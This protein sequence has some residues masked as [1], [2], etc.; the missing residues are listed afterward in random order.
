V[1]GA[2]WFDHA[3]RLHAQHPDGPLPH[4]GRPFP[5]SLVSPQ[6]ALDSESGSLVAVPGGDLSAADIFAGL[7]KQAGSHRWR[8]REAGVRLV[9]HGATPA[10]VLGGIALLGYA[11]HAEDAALLKVIGLLDGFGVAA[12]EALAA[13]PDATTNLLQLAYRSPDA[14]A[15]VRRNAVTDD[16][17]NSSEALRIA[18]VVRLADAV[19][20]PDADNR[21]LD[22]AARLML[23]MASS[24]HYRIALPKYPDAALVYVALARRLRGPIPLVVSLLEDVRTGF[25][26]A[27]DWEPGRREQ[28]AEELLE[29]VRTGDWT[30]LQGD[31]S[32][33]RRLEWARSVA[34]PDAVYQGFRIRVAVPDP[35]GPGR[36]V[37]A[38][39]L[40][41]GRPVVAAAFDRGVSYPPEHLAGSGRL[42]ARVEP[43]EVRL[44]E[45]WCTESCCGALYVTIAR[46]GGTVIWRG[47]R[48]FSGEDPPPE[49][50]FDAAG[51][52]TEVAR[53]END[54]SWE[55][56]ARTMA[57]LLRDRLRA[58]PDV[59]A[60]WGCGTESIAARS[61]EPDQLRLMFFYPATPDFRSDEPWRQFEYVVAVDDSAVPDQVERLVHQLRTA[62][63]RMQADIVG[64]GPH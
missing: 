49:M 63:P 27:L 33:A 50:R 58:D 43:H 6:A 4:G 59:L 36:D 39:I 21:V 9:R 20:A 15:W 54:H 19:E 61:S 35:A 64:G 13:L 11:G 12:A 38:R 40:V 32:N 1:S 23:A 17:V 62:N 52:D 42:R 24:S 26:A 16:G 18:R 2:S 51:Y 22:Q 45:A 3:L 56:P 14:L 31:P 7:R 10:A 48:G 46:E 37:E 30:Q 60:R 5:Q 47:W 25:A 41:D 34:V 44:A 28:V 53:A 29:T 8:A 55:W 57:R